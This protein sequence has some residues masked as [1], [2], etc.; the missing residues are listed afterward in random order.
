MAGEKLTPGEL[1]WGTKEGGFAVLA[2]AMPLAREKRE[3]NGNLGVMELSA[4]C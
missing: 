4:R 1:G 2:A 3:R